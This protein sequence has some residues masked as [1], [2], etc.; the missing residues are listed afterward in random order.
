[1][2]SHRAL[3]EMRRLAIDRNGGEREHVPV[4]GHLRLNKP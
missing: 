1:M 3:Q 2:P 4:V